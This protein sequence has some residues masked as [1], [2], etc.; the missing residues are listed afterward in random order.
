M[1]RIPEVTC[2]MSNCKEDVVR[3]VQ[4]QAIVTF[5]PPLNN[6]R[7]QNKVKGEMETVTFQSTECPFQN[8]TASL[9]LS[10]SV[11]KRVSSSSP[12]L[13]ALLFSREVAGGVG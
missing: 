2:F 8:R 3:P 1:N 6:F 4:R 10:Y 9:H 5:S 12:E 13:V 11:D 7:Y